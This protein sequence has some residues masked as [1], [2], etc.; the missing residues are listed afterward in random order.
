MSQSIE[1]RHSRVYY[2]TLYDT[3]NDLLIAS[4]ED[5]EVLSD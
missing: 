4:E 1:I 2:T 3:F 5:Q